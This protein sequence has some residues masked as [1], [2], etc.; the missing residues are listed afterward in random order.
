MEATEQ[1]L[2]GNIGLIVADLGLPLRSKE[3]VMKPLEGTLMLQTLAY[4]DVLIPTVVYSTTNIP[5]EDIR[6][7]DFITFV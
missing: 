5:E 4:K 2:K 7:F 1:I 6:E 3:M